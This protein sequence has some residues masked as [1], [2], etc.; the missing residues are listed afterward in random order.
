VLGNIYGNSLK[1]N[2]AILYNKKMVEK[3]LFAPFVAL[4]GNKYLFLEI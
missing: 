2:E 3:S 4:R 1:Q